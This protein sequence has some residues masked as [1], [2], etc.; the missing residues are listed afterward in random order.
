MSG[1]IDV[2]A[3]VD[4]D[5]SVDRKTVT[6]STNAVTPPLKD[7]V[8]SGKQNVL[9]NFRSVTYNFTLAALRKEHVNKP[10]L[11]TKGPLELI[12]LKSG[13]KGDDPLTS[14]VSGV[15]TVSNTDAVVETRDILGNLI[16]VKNRAV[17]SDTTTGKELVEEFNKVSP[18][19]FDMYLDDVEI[20]TL[21][22][23]TE[24]SNVTIPVQISFE[25]F[26]PYGINGFLEA[27]HV[28]AVAAGYANYHQASFIL[29][30][31]FW[32]Y[33]DTED[34]AEPVQIPE[35]T[36]FFPIGFVDLAVDVTEQGTKYR[37][38]AV[39]YADRA[40][41]R[42]NTLTSPVKME[43]STVGEILTNFMRELNSRAEVRL[44]ANP[45]DEPSYSQGNNDRYFIKFPSW[46][47]NGELVDSPENNIPKSKLINLYRDNALYSM[48][49]PATAKDNAYRTFRIVEAGTETARLNKQA[50]NPNNR[51]PYSAISSNSQSDANTAR[52][53]KQAGNPGNSSM[54]YDAKT[55]V[56]QF[57]ANSTI[58]DIIIAVIKDSE[59]TRNIIENPTKSIDSDGFIDYFSV[60]IEVANRDVYDEASKKPFQDI[61]Y[62]V[63]PFKIH[64]S[65]L[66]T[67]GTIQTSADKLQRISLREYNYLYSGE[68]V[69][70]L[71]FK[72][73]FNTLFFEAV[74]NAM[75]NTDIPSRR[76]GAGT[77]SDPKVTLEGTTKEEASKQ[78]VPVNPV[79]TVA[80]PVQ[81]NTLNAAQ[82]LTTPYAAMAK[83]MHDAI[84]NSSVALATGTLEI[85]GDPFYVAAGGIGSYNPPLIRKG[86][87]EG[88]DIA[89]NYG[90][91]I[92]IINFKNPS[93]I[94]QDGMLVFTDKVAFSGAY[95]VTNV[96]SK[97]S[98]GQFKQEL[99][100]LRL[101]GQVVDNVSTANKVNPKYTPSEKPK[102]AT[103]N[104]TTNPPSAR[105]DDA[106]ITEQLGRKLPNIGLPGTGSNFT[107]ATGGLGGNIPLLSN[108]VL[109]AAAKNNL[110]AGSAVVGQPLPTSLSS[111]IRLWASGLPSLSQVGLS[112]AALVAIASN[113]ATG[114]LSKERAAGVLAGTVISGTLKTAISAIKN[115]GSGIG[116]KRTFAFY[117]EGEALPPN[118]I[119]SISKE[120]SKIKESTVSAVS[121][122]GTYANG[123]VNDVS[124]NVNKLLS[125]KADPANIAARMGFDSSKLSG[126][127]GK[128]VS[129]VGNQVNDIVKNIPQNVN[130]TQLAAGGL[131]TKYLSASTIK[132][133]PASQLLSVAKDPSVVISKLSSTEFN[134]L[135]T[136]KK[137]TNLVDLTSAKDKLA[138]AKSQ[139]SSITKVPNILDSNA[140]SS[141]SNKFRS[142]STG[143]SPLDKLV[144]K[145]LSDPNA[146]PYTGSDPIIR[147]RLG[148]PPV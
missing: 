86:T 21:M 42:S 78:E 8:K 3:G 122:L 53:N 83:T 60:K 69:D 36:R 107:A 117:P 138:S 55:T 33:P 84:I 112:S 128:L 2:K 6:T 20:G 81:S 121:Q 89:Y 35:S 103:S 94:G 148:L 41:G 51:T 145:A 104:A 120:F 43:G 62:V 19:R 125:T 27:L 114:N 72:L 80:I 49:D 97:F 82:P 75:G 17:I 9:N 101:P 126:L 85:I 10:E 95:K 100:I 99:T 90:D 14:N 119:S 22:G 147:N 74:P 77:A 7:I 50:S 91:L 38:K 102:E 40:F 4:S 44:A 106:T 73:N 88:G 98:G 16:E 64:H 58:S 63:V 132:N 110:A 124:A 54:S 108:Q 109:G 52:L 130:L 142:L 116:E 15:D 71:N 87:F 46:S 111:N 92:I 31:E 115:K 135:A 134:P 28:T 76:T 13:G 144:N 18:G 127:S 68:N 141:V 61:T 25:V 137:S 5:Q 131:A 11:Y 26:E 123:L 29:K 45:R 59:Y 139:L 37:V 32:G 129:K 1:R 65:R 133:L 24:K 30:L 79:K 47:P 39:P 67:H 34:F 140:L 12:I 96:S 66:P 70:V 48:V 105:A 136:L 146:P 93:D 143:Q 118:S 23:F 113:V 57:P 56:V